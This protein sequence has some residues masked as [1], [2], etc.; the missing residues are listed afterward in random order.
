MF[1]YYYI[2]ETSTTT[3]TE[4]LSRAATN[5]SIEQYL[6]LKNTV[7]ENGTEKKAHHV[8]AEGNLSVDRSSR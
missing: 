8:C 4:F 7:I 6:L 3:S 5:G 2:Y 1:L